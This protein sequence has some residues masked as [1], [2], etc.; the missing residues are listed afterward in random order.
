MNRTIFTALVASFLALPA[1]ATSSDEA[2]TDHDHAM[3]AGHNHAE[4]EHAG[5]HE[6]HDHEGHD[7]EAG[8]EDDDHDHAEGHDHDHDHGAARHLAEIGDLRLIHGWAVDG[9]DPLLVFVEIQNI[10]AAMQVLEEVHGDWGSFDIVAPVLKEGEITLTP[11]RSLPLPAGSKMML[12]PGSVAIRAQDL[13]EDLHEGH[14]EQLDLHFSGGIEAEIDV[15]IMPEGT[16]RH[17]HAG[18]NH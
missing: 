1:L 9:A 8:H 17:P 5:G 2:T 11:M 4:D 18:H 6:G 13:T 10:G 7:H 3:E 16:T 14:I 12:A 15:E